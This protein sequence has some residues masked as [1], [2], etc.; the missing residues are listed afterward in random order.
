MSQVKG[1]ITLMHGLLFFKHT[2]VLRTGYFFP[3]LLVF[4]EAYKDLIFITVR[5]GRSKSMN[6]LLYCSG[7]VRQ[8]SV[9]LSL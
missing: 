9:R 6:E 5:E 8:A 7:A 4:A 3:P 1:V 2:P